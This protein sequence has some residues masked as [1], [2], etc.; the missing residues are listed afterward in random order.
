MPRML[1]CNKSPLTAPSLLL[2]LASNSCSAFLVHQ[3][4]GTPGSKGRASNFN[5][6]QL[7]CVRVRPPI[8]RYATCQLNKLYR[9]AEA[10]PARPAHIARMEKA[11]PLLVSCTLSLTKLWETGATA[12]AKS[13]E[14]TCVSIKP[15]MVAMDGVAKVQIPTMAMESTIKFFLCPV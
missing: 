15:R 14:R 11:K 12:D 7:R 10:E 2:S 13:P 5:I 4:V 3:L 6:V 8:M 1:G 9:N